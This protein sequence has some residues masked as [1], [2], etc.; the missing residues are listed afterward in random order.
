[1]SDKS[2]NPAATYDPVSEA[3]YLASIW[4]LSTPK[5]N[6]LAAALLAAEQRGR[7]AERRQLEG[8][9]DYLVEA[10]SLIEDGEGDADVIARQSLIAVNGTT[11]FATSIAAA[12]RK[13]DAT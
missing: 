8:K 13:G 2:I 10:L 4:Q 12:I 3:S 11:D 7:D 6:M 1:M 5:L 9:F